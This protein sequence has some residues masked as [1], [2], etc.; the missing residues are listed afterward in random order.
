MLLGTI[1]TGMSCWRNASEFMAATSYTG[2][3]LAKNKVPN[4]DIY[5]H[6][7]RIYWCNFSTDQVHSCLIAAT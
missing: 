5:K 3:Y 4:G 6:L 2:E 7:W 1:N